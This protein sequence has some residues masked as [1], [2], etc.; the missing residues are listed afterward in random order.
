MT[1]PDPLSA[2][3]AD[4]STTATRIPKATRGPDGN[5]RPAGPPQEIEGFFIAPV[6]TAETGDYSTVSTDRAIGYA[7]ARYEFT[8]D[9][10]I[11]TPDGSVLPGR[12]SVDGTPVR[13]P[14]G[15]QINL[16]RRSGR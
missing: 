4:W 1:S 6:R 15:W 9:D 16:A 7:P 13:W 5:F 8:N 10:E 14:A 11:T 3:P 12:W 2:L